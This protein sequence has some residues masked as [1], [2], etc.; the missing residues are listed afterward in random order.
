MIVQVG[1]EA[2]VLAEASH[3]R[4]AARPLRGIPLQAADDVLTFAV[5]DKALAEA[6]TRRSRNA[7]ASPRRK[8]AD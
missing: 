5:V 7:S 3:P 2:G 4:R 8:K 1:H 6:A